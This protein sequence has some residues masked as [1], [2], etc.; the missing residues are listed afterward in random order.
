[1][2]EERYPSREGY[3]RRVHRAAMELVA[4]RYLLAED[5]ESIVT[6]AALR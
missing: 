5:V 3:L 6:R 2:I 4:G 1:L